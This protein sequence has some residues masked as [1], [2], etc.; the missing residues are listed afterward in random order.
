MAH[1]HPL[2]L[3]LVSFLLGACVTGGS[4]LDLAALETKYAAP[5]KGAVPPTL[6]EMQE[7]YDEFPLSHNSACQGDEF[8]DAHV[9]KT[10]I[11][12]SSTISAIRNL[13]LRWR[14]AANIAVTYGDYPEAVRHIR[15]GGT[16]FPRD[17][18]LEHSRLIFTE[19]AIHALVGNQAAATEA[20]QRA[21]GRFQSGR[22]TQ[23]RVYEQYERYYISSY[24]AAWAMVSFASQAYRK[25]ELLLREVRFQELD[26]AVN[27]KL[28]DAI[29]AMAVAQQGRLE[30]AKS[31]AWLSMSFNI[32]DPIALAWYADS[33]IYALNE[34]SQY[35]HAE[36]L[37]RLFVTFFD[38]NCAPIEFVPAHRLHVRLADALLGAGQKVEA[39]QIYNRLLE[40]TG[41]DENG[42]LARLMEN[43]PY[44]RAVYEGDDGTRT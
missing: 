14:E 29:L 17:W 15:A 27:H 39:L 38:E 12:E 24:N 5:V 6:S 4:T 20:F 31:I 11:P 26:D 44:L 28:I 36:W 10:T 18:K 2:H 7:W 40:H 16:V 21:R 8:Y 37:A 34:Q 9:P 22:S 23:P 43:S 3:L 30:E 41:E 13:S 25:A 33:Y 35:E 19:A 42:W 32:D 1:Q